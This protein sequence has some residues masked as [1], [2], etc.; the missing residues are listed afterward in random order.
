MANLGCGGLVLWAFSDAPALGRLLA[1]YVVHAAEELQE[2]RLCTLRMV[3]AL[4]T[5]AG[6]KSAPAIVDLWSHPLLQANRNP[7]VR[8]VTSTS[9]ALEVVQSGSAAPVASSRTM[10]LAMNSASQSQE[11]ETPP[12]FCQS[13]NHCSAWPGALGFGRLLLGRL[14]EGASGSGGGRARMANSMGG[15][16]PQRG[17]R[18]GG[19]ASFASRASSD[20]Y[21]HQ[22][23]APL[24]ACALLEHTRPSDD[25]AGRR[26]HFRG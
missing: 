26:G 20:G 13:R 3:V 12:A 1:A 23:G 9:Q 10:V 21:K 16:G 19:C 4:D 17:L 25:L 2:R 18:G 6:C 7:M 22:C 8:H 14:D 15:P 11:C 5:L 24:V